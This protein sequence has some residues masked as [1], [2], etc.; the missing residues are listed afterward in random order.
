MENRDLVE[1]LGRLFALARSENWNEPVPGRE[2]P[3]LRLG[4]LVQRIA[5]VL[6]QFWNEYPE[7]VAMALGQ[8]R[9]DLVAEIVSCDLHE[10][11]FVIRTHRILLENDIS[12]KGADER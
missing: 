8:F 6:P 3:T 10:L 1:H 5:S 2:T 9:T 12:R 4:I 7:N 11:G